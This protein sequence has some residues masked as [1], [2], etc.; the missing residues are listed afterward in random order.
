M[1][2]IFEKSMDTD[3]RVGMVSNVLK[4]YNNKVFVQNDGGDINNPFHYRMG[5]PY[6]DFEPHEKNTPIYWGHLGC[7]IFDMR[8][9]REI[10]LFDENFFIYSS[11]FDIQI[12]LKM[13]GFYIWHCPD[14]TAYHKTFHTCNEIKKKSQN[15]TFDGARWN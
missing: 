3:S 8:V 15:T 12:R 13:A 4:D 7:T 5:W 9:F 11:D 6:K 2:K 1:M 14:S 10:G